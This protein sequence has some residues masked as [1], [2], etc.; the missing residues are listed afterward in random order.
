[1]RIARILVESPVPRLDRLLDYEIPD[2]LRSEA[3]TGV[4]VRVPLGRGGRLVEG[5][6]VELAEHA[7]PGITPAAIDSVLGAVSVLTPA[8]WATVRAAADRNGGSASDILRIA[9]PKRAVRVE[10]G[11]HIPPRP[12]IDPRP[13]RKVV[14][15]LP[16]GISSTPHGPTTNAHLRV[17]ELVKQSQG[18][19]IVVVPDW[20]DI[21]LMT[22]ALGEIPHVVW[23]STGTPSERYARYLSILGGDARVVIG[24]RSAVYAPVRDLDTLIVLNESDP[25]LDEPLAPFVHTR[26]AAIIRH[27][28]EGGTLIFASTTP[29]VELARFREL[30]FVEK[31]PAPA[32]PSVGV[33]RPHCVLANDDTDDSYAG[34]A[35]IPASAWRILRDSLND[36][37]VLVQVAR[38]GFTPSIVCAA[39]RTPHRCARCR[40]PLAGSR[41]GTTVCRVCGNHPIGIVC[42]RCGGR[43]IAL[44]GAGS[45]RTADELGRAFPGTRVVVAD[46]DHRQLEIPRGKTLVVAT[47]GAEPIVDGGYRAVLIVDGDRELQRPGLRTTE[48]CLRW[49]G[50]A[51]SLLGDGGTMVLANIEGAIGALFAS[52]QW[53]AVVEKELRDRRAL[54]FPPATR[55]VAVSGDIAE[56]S[57]IRQLPELAE[58]KI[59]GPAMVGKAHRLVLLVDYATAPIVIA[60][61]RRHIVSSGKSTVRI[62]CDD[63]GVFDEIDED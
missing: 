59:L 31:D 60:A 25:L 55:S 3:V 14:V 10:A 46:G 40:S 12:R 19:V 23:D 6:V 38:P 33:E 22:R 11:R 24:L 1:M 58:A 53:D 17:A 44:S 43:E 63:L 29:S 16:T 50:S 9:I 41:D 35:R 48:N 8:L 57:R 27:A 5:F 36:G 26:D 62:H 20:R 47:R 49:W 32:E 39:C 51:A 45:V 56:L 37:P 7:Q 2:P 54:G 21:T 15:D 61:V 30:D 52:G 34:K 4:R 13:G 18:G 28:V 42:P